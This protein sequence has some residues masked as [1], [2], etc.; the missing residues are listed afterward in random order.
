MSFL[1]PVSEPVMRFSSTDASAPKINYNT[2]TAG[3]VKAVLKACLVTGYGAKA[4]AGWTAVNETA[5]VIEFVSPSAAMSDY[6]LGIDDTSAAS[7]TWYYQYQ[8][9]P[10]NPVGGSPAK[11][12]DT[13]Y[14]N[15]TH[16]DNGWTLLVTPRGLMFVELVYSKAVSAIVCR[17]TYFGMLKLNTA[18]IGINACYF[19]VGAGGATTFLKD[20][21]IGAA[22]ATHIKI[23]SIAA[24]FLHFGSLAQAVPS[25][26]SQVLASGVDISSPLYIATNQRVFVA[27]QPGLLLSIPSDASI[28]GGVSEL[29]LDDRPLLGLYIADINFT[30][31]E[32]VKRSQRV[33]L[34][35]D[36]W[37]F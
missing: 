8:D 22:T 6:R 17:L 10:T 35:L 36:S 28:V 25:N 15:L 16:G 33:M 2:R 11:G 30:P 9:V 31:S 12:Y 18:S 23:N 4:S 26:Q 5:T 13:S 27:Q 24:T 7:T 29:T 34:R 3:D 32:V 37:E 14:F 19:N 20:W 21:I 1:K